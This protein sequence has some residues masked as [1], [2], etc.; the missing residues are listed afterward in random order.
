M[1][2]LLRYHFLLL[3]GLHFTPL[4]IFFSTW[5]ISRQSSGFWPRL[6]TGFVRQQGSIW[7]QSD[8]GQIGCSCSLH[9]I[10]V[11]HICPCQTSEHKRN[12]TCLCILDVLF[13]NTRLARFVF[14]SDMYA[15]VNFFIQHILPLTFSFILYEGSDLPDAS[16]IP[17]GAHL[18]S[19]KKEESHETVSTHK[20]KVKIKSANVILSQYYHSNL[21]QQILIT[22][23]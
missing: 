5:R 21:K 13:R 10:H 17:R 14:P 3:H 18:C 9:T 8:S 7:K 2:G 22:G 19:K 1:E 20:T 15:N 4:R 23:S 11:Q 12:R 6:S 16:C